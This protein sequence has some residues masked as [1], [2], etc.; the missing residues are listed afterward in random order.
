MDGSLK[1]KGGL[2]K[3]QAAFYGQTPNVQTRAW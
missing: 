2:I 3:N 1:R